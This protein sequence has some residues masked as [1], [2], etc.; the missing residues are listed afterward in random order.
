VYSSGGSVANLL[1]LGAARQSA[2][3]RIGCDPAADGVARRVAV[4]ASRE[5]HHT[6]QRSAGVLGIG[7]RAVRPV[8]CD[9]RG[10]MRVDE[11]QRLLNED[12]RAGV[13]PLAIVANAGTTNTGAI[14]DLPALAAVCHARGAWLHV[15]GAYGAFAVLTERGRAAL[16]GLA[17]ADSVTLDPHKWL[18]MPF[19]VGCLLVRDGAALER[20]FELHPEYLKE[21]L[22]AGRG[23]NFADRGLQLTRA[24]RAIKVWL[25]IQTFGVD[26]FRAVIDRAM[27]FALEAERRIQADPRLELC[28]AASLGVVTFRRRG[29][30]DDPPAE[31]DRLN[32]RIV[33]SLA[34]SGDVLLTSTFIGGRYVIRLCV[35]NHTS[36]LDDVI[37]ALDRVAEADVAIDGTDGV[38]TPAP[39]RA[40]RQ[41]ATEIQPEHDERPVAADVRAV[42]AFDGATVGE[43]EQLL[44]PARLE[45][46]RTGGLV[47]ERWARAR[48]FYLVRSGRLEVRIDD[49]V[50]N[51]LGPGDPFGE[52]AAIDWGRD[53]S[54]G[55][56]ATVVALEPTVLVAIPAAALRSVM[57]ASPAV[58]RA[59]RRIAQERLAAR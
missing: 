23:V 27:D 7:R 28:S 47:T 37:Y 42:A 12:R 11:L 53:F 43:I 15:D 41:A 13:L 4:Y 38:G 19:E 16:E 3:E 9:E 21:N 39:E 30:P 40:A 50:V 22:G 14:D 29:S 32:E 34:E 24:S 46:V 35:L 51:V 17:L 52:V 20:A 2:F 6:I 5:A 55:R 33:A 8:A 36:E 31:V 49:R 1:A 26:A 44:A 48:T 58:D 56:T 54:Y 59:I 10:R 18:A 45:R 57:A 25:A